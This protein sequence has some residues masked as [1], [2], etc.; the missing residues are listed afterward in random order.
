MNI[1]LYSS[2]FSELQFTIKKLVRIIHNN[3]NSTDFSHF[4][5][6]KDL[7]SGMKKQEKQPTF[8]NL[9]L[10]LDFYQV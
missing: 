3:T 7:M 9:I 2:S 4:L 10:T 5:S 6:N 8:E 1:K